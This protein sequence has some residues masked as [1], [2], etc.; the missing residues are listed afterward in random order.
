MLESSFTTS[1]AFITSNPITDADN[2]V[3]QPFA[4]NFNFKRSKKYLTF[5]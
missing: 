2:K 3:Q 4:G 1:K 5:V